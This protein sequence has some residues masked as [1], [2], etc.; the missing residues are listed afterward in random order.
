MVKIDECIHIQKVMFSSSLLA[1]LIAII[2]CIFA[3]KSYSLPGITQSPSTEPTTKKVLLI[4]LCVVFG[5][6]IGYKCAAKKA[7]Y[8]LNPCHVLTL[9]EVKVFNELLKSTLQL[10]T[11]I[12]CY[13]Y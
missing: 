2:A 9:M 8:L 4:L 11:I 7:L 3:Y 6:E 12:H 10:I 1:A 13:N 5:A